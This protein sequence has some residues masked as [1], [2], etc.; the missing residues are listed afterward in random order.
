MRKVEGQRMSEVVEYRVVAVK[1]DGN[2]KAEAI[3]SEG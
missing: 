1:R 3:S 2:E